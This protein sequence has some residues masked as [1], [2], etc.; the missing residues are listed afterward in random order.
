MQ[1]LRVVWFG[2]FDGYVMPLLWAV[3]IGVFALGLLLTIGR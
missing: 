3:V 1:R 2:F